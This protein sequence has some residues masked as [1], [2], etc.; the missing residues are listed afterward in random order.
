MTPL[1]T[2]ELPITE[3]PFARDL[4]AGASTPSTCRHPRIPPDS[5]A[6]RLGSASAISL[7]PPAPYRPPV[8]ID[9]C[10]RCGVLVEDC[11]GPRAAKGCIAG[12]RGKSGRPCHRWVAALQRLDGKLWKVPSS[13]LLAAVAALAFS[14][15]C[16]A[17]I[18]TYVEKYASFWPA[19]GFAVGTLLHLTPLQAA[20]FTPMVFLANFLIT[21]QFQLAHVSALF[22]GVNF[23][24]Y[25]GIFLLIKLL[26]PNYRD[27]ADMRSTITMLLAI[28]V[29]S[30]LGGLFGSLCVV[31]QL[32]G[33]L[34]IELFKWFISDCLGNLAVIPFFLAAVKWRIY[35]RRLQREPLWKKLLPVF[36]WAIIATLELSCHELPDI[37]YFYLNGPESMPFIAHIF[38]FPFILIAGWAMG[39]LGYTSATLTL[40]LTGVAGIVFLSGN[41]EPVINM[42]LSRFQLF[43]LMTLITSQTLMTVEKARQRA[44]ADSLHANHNKTRFMAFLCHELRN[45][46][47]A[48]VNIAALLKETAPPQPPPPPPSRSRRPSAGLRP[49]NASD[50]SAT[51]TAA[52]GA[53]YHR[54][55]DAIATAGNYMCQI[56]DDVLETSKLEQS[57]VIL[58]PAE[59]DIASILLRIGEQTRHDLV[60][61][62]V[63][64]NL[65]VGRMA[66]GGACRGG[67]E[68]CCEDA[69]EPLRSCLLTDESRIKQLFTNLLANAI[70]VT[71]PHHAIDCRLWCEN[72]TASDP[73]PPLNTLPPSHLLRILSNRFFPFLPCSSHS[74]PFP[75]RL[76][77]LTDPADPS[78]PY[79][80]T[81]LCFE[82]SDAGPAPSS[83]DPDAPFRPFEVK[84]VEGP[85]SQEYTGS[86]LGLAICKQLVTLMG[87][88]IG[89]RPKRVEVGV[90]GGGGTGS[91]I[92]VR[93]PM[94]AVNPRPCEG[95]EAGA[96]VASETALESAGPATY[97]DIPH[98]APAAEDASSPHVVIEMT[99]LPTTASA[100]AHPP[101]PART[102]LASSIGMLML[103][104]GGVA[105][106][107][108]PPRSIDNVTPWLVASASREPQLDERD[109]SPPAE[110]SRSEP[111]PSPS[112]RMWLG[113]E[114]RGWK[115]E[116]PGRRFAARLGR[117]GRMMAS[118]SRG[119]KEGAKKGNDGHGSMKTED[120]NEEEERGESSNA[121]EHPSLNG[122]SSDGPSSPARIATTCDVAAAA[123][124]PPSLCGSSPPD[125]IEPLFLTAKTVSP[126]VSLPS[127]IIASSLGPANGGSS[128]PAVPEGEV[129]KPPPPVVEAGSVKE[130]LD[131]WVDTSTEQEEVPM[132]EDESLV[133]KH[134]ECDERNGPGPPK[135][136][137][138]PPVGT[139]ENVLVDREGSE[140]PPVLE[141]RR[142]EDRQQGEVKRSDLVEGVPNSKSR[143][144]LTADGSHT[145]DLEPSTSHSDGN[146]V[147]LKPA[148]PP[149][150]TLADPAIPPKAILIVDDSSLN[151]KI[152]TRLLQK[153]CPNAILHEA[154]NGLEAVTLVHKSRLPSSSPQRPSPSDDEKDSPVTYAGILMDLQMPVMDGREATRKIRGMG[155]HELPIVAVTA[156]FVEEE[157]LKITDG[158]TCLAPKPFLKQDAEKVLQMF[159][160]L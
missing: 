157:E 134:L 56:I 108:L 125:A 112:R 23:F 141:R 50:V 100:P 31:W 17:S 43:L 25:M 150:P 33:V 44:L 131:G 115:R 135:P 123:L 41:T 110:A 148:P 124:D 95:C 36:C 94:L 72:P 37:Y 106:A 73:L 99:S 47:H 107:R 116:G 76:A 70:K 98:A 32:G 142:T 75:P 13:F 81:M 57:V 102:R 11:H 130:D 53:E 155:W 71:S 88:T 105:P 97:I 51:A 158:F 144:G 80:R 74:H 16:R 122:A 30:L 63:R 146:P 82:V 151:R 65:V 4:E 46:L 24:E 129:T 67:V 52:A 1:T 138:G 40:C 62:N 5:T 103:D 10:E 104:E 140:R 126:P 152:L 91:T 109:P 92:F 132:R 111:P 45:P 42:L 20:F 39:P 89:I 153:A 149:A 120:S 35:F 79:T 14:G 118:E 21:A 7:G 147:E 156:S 34:P 121:S 127:P 54:L 60:P 59:V 15:V 143:L 8:D 87:G 29:V 66:G 78:S 128:K 145:N 119:W 77:T 68:G 6:L 84:P 86:G 136:V 83:A 61:R 133:G 27:L 160:V 12:G 3:Q 28:L 18:T 19:N 26:A 117:R 93:L 159:G 137:L 96:A 101:T 22:A 38:S 9:I 154:S 55:C 113:K 58:K 139:S 114:R 48:V 90:E 69:G 2:K 85:L 49:D 64:F